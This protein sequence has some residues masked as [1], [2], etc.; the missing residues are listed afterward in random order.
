MKNERKSK[1]KKEKNR[2]Q[3]ELGYKDGMKHIIKSL[4]SMEVITVKKISE[5]SNFTEQEIQ[6]LTSRK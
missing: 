3:Y 2:N 6:E 1:T 4:F 5:I